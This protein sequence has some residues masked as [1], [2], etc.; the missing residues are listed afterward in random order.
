MTVFVK[1]RHIYIIAALTLL[2]AGC[3]QT[4]TEKSAKHIANGIK[5][6]QQHDAPRAV[7][8]FRNAVQAL[9]GSAEA[10]YQ[11]GIAYLATNDP[12]K[13]VGEL[14]RAIAL[15]PKH[16][17]AQL[18]LAQLLSSV[19]NP[20]ML[21]DAEQRLQLLI[22]D[23]PD[24]PGALHTLGLTELKLGEA[25]DAIR[26]LQRALAI[27][28]QELT[29]SV[30]LAQ[31]KLQQ[32][33][34]KGAEE[35]LKN[36]ATTSPKS[37]DAAILLARFYAYN[38]DWGKAEEQLQRALVLEPRSAAAWLNLAAIQLQTGRKGEAEQSYKKL[39]ALPYKPTQST[40]GL[41]LFQ[42]GRR[43]EAIHEFERLAKQDADDR[44]ARTRLVAAY[45]ES[46]RVSDARRVLTDALK[47][48][49][50]DLDALLQRGE[51]ALADGKFADA[52]VDLNQVLH[53]KA[54]SAEAHYAL[55]GLHNARGVTLMY[56]Q[57]LNEVLRLNPNLVAV[58]VEL[59][60]SLIASNNAKAALATLDGTPESQRTLVPLIEQRNWAL[61]GVDGTAEARK[62]IDQ[63]LAIARTPDLLLQDAMLKIAARQYAE[64]RQVLKEGLQ[65][66]PED[67]RLLR[68]LMGSY[69]AQKEIPKGVT[70][71]RAHADSHPNSPEVQYFL[72][73]LLLETGQKAEAH[74]A[75]T[76]AVKLNPQYIP[77]EMEL[78][79]MNLTQSN[80]TDARQQLTSLLSSHDENP[81]AHL[82]LGMLEESVG[83]HTA[84][85]NAFQR[86]F[87]V[88]PNN[89][90]TLNN[91]A[92]TL[93]EY[94]NRPDEALKL[95]QKAR[96]LSPDNP[97]F[98]DTLGW[99]LFRKGL[100]D[101]AVTQL[102]AAAAKGTDVRTQYHLAMAYLK[103]G[104]ENRGRT[105]LEAAL[106]KNPKLAEAKM[107]SELFQTEKTGGS[108]R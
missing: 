93:A 66:A 40:Y 15:N 62:G 75:F 18:T 74:K 59:C 98:Q 63:G 106:R 108:S 69:A 96:E 99:V 78:V 95:A 57:E 81:V 14:R 52:E 89:P 1:M 49:P 22:R 90:L 101:N 87:E 27:A 46:G 29:Y 86:A 36:A 65:K 13:A 33:D 102:Q 3:R 60:K 72:G 55:A 16:A 31:A 6:L 21:K 94:A 84:A 67:T 44:E 51:L 24:N 47:K 50:K 76:S 100:Y 73:A 4:P 53:L 61:L 45:R 68:A 8:Q 83:N 9:P 80:W 30:T 34:L 91:L 10:H 19:D 97:D 54:D 85:L 35:A 43:E 5:L 17:G 70:E 41:F 71:V 23:G 11:L 2:L 32:N 58:R 28:P 25:S 39:A 56:R 107:A 38:K 82:W 20:E 104:Q 88:E 48:N 12:M 77:A 37:A 105:I 26:H 79:R 7:L 103:A 92:Y 64:A 42:E